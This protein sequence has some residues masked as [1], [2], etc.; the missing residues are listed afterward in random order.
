MLVELHMKF[1]KSSDIAAKIAVLACVSV[2][3]LL[4]HRYGPQQCA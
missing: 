2:K 4:P 1:L 3:S